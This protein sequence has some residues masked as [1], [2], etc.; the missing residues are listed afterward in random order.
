MSEKEKKHR[1][2]YRKNREK[3][4]FAQIVIIAIL[5]VAILISALVAV[6]L[7]SQYYIG[8]TES[9][10]LDYNV[11][12]KDNEFYDTDVLGEG[13]AY[14]ASLIDN[15]VVN[16]NYEIDMETS[17]V[18]YRY[19]YTVKSRLEIVDNGS[20]VAIFNPEYE[21]VSVQNKTQ[22]SASRLRVN[23][24]VVI[25]YDEYN[26]LA[27]RFLNTY[28]L[29]GTTSNIVLTLEVDVLSDCE[30]FAGSA[31][32][33][34]KSELRIPLTTKT[35]NV[36]MTST[37]PSAESTMIACTRGM[38]SEAFKIT[39]M[40]LGV[41]DALMIALLLA[42]MYL[43][44]TAD[45]TYTARVKKIISQYKSFVQ[46][47]NNMFETKGYQVILVDTFDEMLE[48]RDTLQAPILMYEN[49][50][51]T[52]CKFIIPT[53]SKLLY[54]YV[55]CVDGYVEPAAEAE[56]AARPAVAQPAITNVVRPVV[57][58]VVNTAPEKPAEPEAKIQTILEAPEVEA[59]GAVEV[60][61]T[62]E[63]EEPAKEDET[64]EG[65]EE[66]AEESETPEGAEEPAEDENSEN[67]AEV[68]KLIESIPE[69][70]EPQERGVDAIDVFWK[71]RPDK[72]Y[73]Y[74]PD[75]NVV[76][77]G[78]TVLVPTRDVFS[79][80]T[81]VREAEVFKGNYKVDPETLDRPL[82]KIIGVV[83]RKAEQIFT[84]IDR[85]SVV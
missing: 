40:V 26:D 50:D 28:E 12:L 56:D 73:R 32:D 44:R 35:V 79:D 16:F 24:I 34:Y 54:T 21:L 18:N 17:N 70:E 49:M 29:Q 67:A 25:N 52:C 38:G 10:S 47:I 11:F 20:G 22:S 30:A 83:K 63:E 84:A 42:F 41:I 59:D 36:K 43:T 45:I 9:G 74:D 77:S 3:W 66:P 14:V 4:I 2:L 55:I 37:V 64:P 31:V 13:Q 75:G 53:D 68:E 82:K 6:Q 69:A 76:A 78:D 81:I 27:N 65:A 5:A 72:T 57:K 85:K 58:V 60:T 61:A 62:T 15:I 23:E 1:A 19:S 39:A 8:Y 7:K 51:K 48:I 33:S 71:E 80:K 46:K